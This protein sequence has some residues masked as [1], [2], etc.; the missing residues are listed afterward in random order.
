MDRTGD[1]SDIKSGAPCVEVAGGCVLSSSSGIEHTSITSKG[2]GGKSL[3]GLK[4]TGT[5]KVQRDLGEG[6]LLTCLPRRLPG[7]P[8]VAAMM[9]H[10]GISLVT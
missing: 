6:N 4:T 7:C 5:N 10:M 9:F 8:I 2:V 3:E 1:T